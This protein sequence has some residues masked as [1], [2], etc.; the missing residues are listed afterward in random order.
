MWEIA[1]MTMLCI[2]AAV[3]LTYFVWMHSCRRSKESADA[4]IVLGYR[5]DGNQIHPLL[6]ERLD[7]ALRLYRE[8]HYRYLVLSGGAVKS[9]RTEAEI[10]RGYLLD[11]G[12][13]VERMIL[14]S[15][16]RNT[17]HNLVNCKLILTERNLS[18]FVLISNSFHLRRM[19]YIMKTLGL[20]A[21]LYAE[22][23]WSSILRLQWRLTFQEIRA[24]RLTL[25]WLEKAV[26]MKSPQMM[27][28]KKGAASREA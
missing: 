14:E 8:Y 5:C 3:P 10:M 19:R 13:P 11:Q 4:L 7:A 21:S 23:N 18:T 25:P 12:V 1:L 2:I 24:F 6:K 17:V 26:N 27:G 22:R 16:S 9:N 20:T 15:R 28:S